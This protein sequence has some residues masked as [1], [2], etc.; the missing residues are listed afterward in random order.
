M[1]TMRARLLAVFVI[2]FAPWVFGAAQAVNGSSYTFTCACTTPTD[3]QSA[4]ITAN[5]SYQANVT[6]AVV[7]T[8]TAE[9]VFVQVTGYWIV[10]PYN[11]SQEWWTV[12]T[13]T[14]VD[15]N[16]AALSSDVPTAEA[17]MAVIDVGLF[18]FGRSN[19][20]Q[21]ATVTMPSNYDGSFVGS[22]DE[23]DS[24]GIDYAL[25]QMGINPG[26]F[27][28][29]ATILVTY[30]DGSRAVFVK[31]SSVSSY[32]WTWDGLHAWNAAGKPITRSGVVSNNPNS[33][34]SGGG[35][36]SVTANQAETNAATLWALLNMEQCEEQTTYT[37]NGEVIGT[38][39]N[40]I[41]C[42]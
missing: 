24:P 3:F 31:T 34:G 21:V 26:S 41:P 39:Y 37:E 29:G 42:L 5:N 2:F 7:S 6:Y 28:I 13:A 23:Y 20:P 27:P 25:G 38:V 8:T 17:Q 22:A 4:A 18:G 10:N 1:N 36:T 9:S 35:T 12:N 19:T 11:Y 15:L 32:Q 16:G 14:L 40:W 33:S 30:A